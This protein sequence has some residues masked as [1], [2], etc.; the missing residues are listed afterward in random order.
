MLKRLPINARDM[1]QCYAWT[2]ELLPKGPRQIVYDYLQRSYVY[3]F[4][5]NL[6]LKGRSCSYGYRMDDFDLDFK[7]EPTKLEKNIMH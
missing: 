7:I 6:K 3:M 4:T 2:E 1:I 5:L